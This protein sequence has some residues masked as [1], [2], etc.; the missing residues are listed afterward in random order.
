M[1]ITSLDVI[2]TVKD[3]STVLRCVS[4]LLA[5]MH[6]VDT[7]RLGSVLVCDGGSS[8]ADC[9][10]Q[11]AQVAAFP[12]VKVL[13]CPQVGF[14]KSWLLNQ[15][16]MAAIAPMV[17]IS[18]VDILWN[19]ATLCAL[20]TAVKRQPNCI[21]TVQ[22]VTESDPTAQVLRR[23][24][25]A[26]QIVKTGKSTKS[27]QVKIYEASL[28]GENR[29]GCGLLCAQRSVFQQ[30]GGYR[31]CFQGWGWEDQDFLIRAELLGYGVAAV[32]EV[33]HLTHGEASRHLRGC[34]AEE[35]RDRNILRCLQGLTSGHLR[36]DLPITL[37]INLPMNCTVAENVGESFPNVFADPI[38][39]QYPSALNDAAQNDA[40][41]AD[42][43]LSRSPNPPQ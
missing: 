15:G 2:I 23:K 6:W 12:G 30:V 35:S 7:V 3:R 14:N 28:L 4:E 40:A 37:P 41:H 21:Y 43:T 9:L 31:E 24:R 25:Y 29:P 34:A 18:D 36:G 13:R 17:I 1:D 19:A 11:L 42:Y 22:T 5:Q 33:T 39:V 32:G 20:T 10:S 26:Y 27:T 38:H 8:E 16:L